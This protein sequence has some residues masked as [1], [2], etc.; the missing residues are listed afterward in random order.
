M[1]VST[2]LLP[3]VNFATLSCR[4]PE[5][6]ASLHRKDVGLIVKKQHN[7]LASRGMS[8]VVLDCLCLIE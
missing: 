3:S 6:A 7:P 1:W 2:F 4:Y 5:S 8:R